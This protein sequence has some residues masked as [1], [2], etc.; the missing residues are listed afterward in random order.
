MP[1]GLPASVPSGGIQEGESERHAGDWRGLTC[2]PACGTTLHV[3]W[4][5]ARHGAGRRHMHLAVV[6]LTQ[7]VITGPQPGLSAET[8]Y[9]QRE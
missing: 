7:Y 2:W 3:S 1:L 8:V 6:L 9:L 4:P 5:I